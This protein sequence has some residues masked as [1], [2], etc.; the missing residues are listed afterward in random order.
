M[1]WLF[2]KLT[3]PLGVPTDIAL[4]AMSSILMTVALWLSWRLYKALGE[5]DRTAR[6]A[7][8]IL[9]F[10]GVVIQQGTE[11]EVYALQLVLSLAAYLSYVRNRPVLAGLALGLVT[12]DTPLGVLAVGFFVAE[13][14]RTR[15]WKPF[16]IMGV[17]GSLTFLSVL[18]WVWRDYFYGTRGLLVDTNI[19]QNGTRLMANVVAIAKNFHVLLPFLLIGL[20]TAWRQRPR[21]LALWVG[22]LI[23]HIPAILTVTENGVFLLPIYPIFAL[24][25]ALGV[26]VGLDAKGPVRTAT[27]LALVLYAALSLLIWMQPYD[28]KFRD[29]MVEGF[30]RCPPGSAVITTWSFSMTLDFYAGPPRDT[31]V[32]SREL[33]WSPPRAKV[34]AALAAGR[35]VFLMEAH[36]PTRGLRWLY[37][38]E[39]QERHY[40]QNALMPRARRALGVLATP[41]FSR[42]GSP[43][44]YRLSLP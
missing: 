6:W 15:Q 17:V 14:I 37:P 39:W 44:V 28:R 23:L 22:L 16:V 41:Y 19:Q 2:L 1:G 36:V 3:R 31:L 32:A 29:G 25:I 30:R 40:D 42:P 11:A 13:A 43:I 35:P 10:A 5:D 38:R 20:V 24:I 21:L 7:L 26:R 4:V 9:L 12:L 27:G 18:A 34:A 33:W 8:F